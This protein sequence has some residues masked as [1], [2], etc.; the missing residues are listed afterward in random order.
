MLFFK[1]TYHESGGF[2]DWPLN[3]IDDSPT[4]GN[5]KSRRIFHPTLNQLT[6]W[7]FESWILPQ[8]TQKYDKIWQGQRWLIMKIQVICDIKW[9]RY[10]LKSWRDPVKSHH[11]FGCF[12]AK[13]N[14]QVAIKSADLGLDEKNFQKIHNHKWD[15]PC[16]FGAMWY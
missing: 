9:A 2:S 8:N 6:L 15:Y 3:G 11:T 10:V 4:C 14:F 12:E 16:R 7:Q 1:T 13:F 5:I